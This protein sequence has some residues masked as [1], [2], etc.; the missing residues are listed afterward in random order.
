MLFRQTSLYTQEKKQ[1]TKH[2]LVINIH[3]FFFLFHLSKSQLE[4]Q[5]QDFAA[6]PYHQLSIINVQQPSHLASLQLT[7]KDAKAITHDH[8]LL[9]PFVNTVVGTHDNI[10]H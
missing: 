5:I 2:H 6:C 7:C 3:R 4:I 1:N 9:K 10:Q 8:E